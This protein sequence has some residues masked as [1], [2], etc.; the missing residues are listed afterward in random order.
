MTLHLSGSNTHSPQC[1]VLP[2]C[3]DSLNIPLIYIRRTTFFLVQSINC[4]IETPQSPN[5]AS[6]IILRKSST[7]V[8]NKS[9]DTVFK[10]NF[11]AETRIAHVPLNE[12]GG[13]EEEEEVED[14]RRLRLKRKMMRWVFIFRHYVDWYLTEWELTCFSSNC[15]QFLVFRTPWENT[16]AIFCFVSV[17]YHTMEIIRSSILFYAEWNCGSLV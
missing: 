7:R 15:I 10:C 6:L 9:I 4:S 17:G 11:F 5:D 3:L 13:G 14:E 16:A 12:E 1:L 2:V 8:V